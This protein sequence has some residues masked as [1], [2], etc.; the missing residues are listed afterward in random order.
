MRRLGKADASA[1]IA[2]AT[3]EVSPLDLVWYKAD[4]CQETLLLAT[5]AQK[6]KLIDGTV[7][8]MKERYAFC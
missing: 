6:L 4:L 8:V 7:L 1:A 3:Q 2:V 5:L